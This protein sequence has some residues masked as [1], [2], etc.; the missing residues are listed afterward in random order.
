MY[1]DGREERGEIILPGMY[2]L[3]SLLVMMIGENGRICQ[4]QANSFLLN[5]V[6]CLFH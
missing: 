1:G 3:Q 2:I 5:P 4:G 6:Y